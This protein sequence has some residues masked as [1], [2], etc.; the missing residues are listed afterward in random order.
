MDNKCPYCGNEME[1]GILQTG[2]NNIIYDIK[3]HKIWAYP[4]KQGFQLVYHPPGQACIENVWHC[5]HCKM[6]L[7]NYDK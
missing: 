2:G 5:K 4:S 1:R 6:I 7:F 3:K